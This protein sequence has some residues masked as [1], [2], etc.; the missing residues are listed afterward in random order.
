MKTK[1]RN[2]SE[3]DKKTIR[4]RLKRILEKHTEISFG[5][6]H[7]SFIS[8]GSFADIDVALYL[9]KIPESPVEYELPLESELMKAAD[10]Y[11][12]DV[13]ILNRAP[14]SFRYQVIKNGVSLIVND[15]DQ[16]VAFQEATLADYFDFA[17]YRAMYLK[18]T[19]GLG[20]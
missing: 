6:L 16:R 7:G 18:E 9:R 1:R 12:V 8:G 10:A 11:P 20:V 13:R 5:Y 4:D 17:P 3:A 19:L 2:I 15:D 14:L